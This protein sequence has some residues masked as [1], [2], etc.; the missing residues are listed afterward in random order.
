MTLACLIGDH[1]NTH[2]EW[3][4]WWSASN[5][6]CYWLGN[7]TTNHNT[8]LRIEAFSCRGSPVKSL[9][10]AVNSSALFHSFLSVEELRVIRWPLHIWQNCDSA[11]TRNPNPNVRKVDDC[12]RHN[13]RILLYLLQS[14][15]P[16]RFHPRHVE[17]R[18]C[19][20]NVT[21]RHV[22]ATILTVEKQWVLHDLCSFVA[23]GIQHAQLSSVARP[24]QQK[25]YTL[26]H[27]RHNFRKKV[28]EYKM[29][30]SSFSTTFVW[31]IF[32]SNKNWERERERERKR[33]IENVYWSARKVPF[34]L[35][36]F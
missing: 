35:D 3:I 22:R 30:V 9:F 36:W 17:T 23:L 29:G 32:Y 21:L 26:S 24:A 33:E 19:M 8:R 14:V 6:S 20:H 25:F 18:Q 34:I 27:K 12:S 10:G 31:N 28:I 1:K 5:A 15:N 11:N 16:I 7:A 2:R 13:S 4:L